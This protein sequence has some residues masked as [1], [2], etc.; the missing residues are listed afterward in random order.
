ML[1]SHSTDENKHSLIRHCVEVAN[2]TKEILD[3]TS[4][5][6][7]EAGFYAGLLHDLGKI[8]PFYQEL[9]SDPTKNK[10]AKIKELESKYLREHSR[11]SA[12][13]AILLLEDKT[14]LDYGTIDIISSVVYAHHSRLLRTL[15][16]TESSDRLAVTQ[17][18]ISEILPEFEN[19]ARP[20]GEFS[21]LNW[22]RCQRYFP[23]PIKFG[24]NLEHASD[25]SMTDFLRIGVLFSALLQADRGSFSEWAKPKFD[26]SI[27]TGPLVKVNSPLSALR[28]SFGREAE[29]NHDFANSVNV[30]NAPTGIGKTKVFLDL[31]SEYVKKFSI[32]RVF[33][34]SP[35]LALTDD[36]E[37]KLK[38]TISEK[39]WGE[40][41]SYTHLFS[42][43]LEKKMQYESGIYEG[44][45]WLF[46]DESFNQKFIITTT[47]RLLMTLY[48]NSY[49]DKIKLASFKNSLLIID[50]IQTIPKF[51]LSNLIE[52][53]QK[54]G[55]LMNCK[56]LLVSATIPYELSKLPR[57]K[58][59]DGILSLYL[60]KTKK[61]ISFSRLEI[62]DM[63]NDKILVMVNTK[64][65]AS[66]IFQRLS[67]GFSDEKL[68]YLSTGV[69]K[70]DRLD[71]L[72]KLSNVNDC[73]CVSTQVI[74]AGVDISFSQIFRE[75]APLDSIVQV[76]GRLNRE[77]SLQNSRLTIFQE[78]NNWVPYSELEYNE[79]LEV[80]K[81]ISTSVDLY[82]ALPEYYHQVSERNQRNR[83]LADALVYSVKKMDFAQVWEFIYSNVLADDYQETVFIPDNEKQWHDLK[84]SIMSA[85]RIDKEISR[86]YSYYTA[87]LSSS[88]TKLGIIDNFDEQLL[89][90][91]ILLPKLEH[92]QEMYHPKIGL[93]VWLTQ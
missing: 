52:Y 93:D 85:G 26:I 15:P 91:N 11:F 22:E 8:N 45:H 82:D 57:T 80:L 83:D 33:Y 53:F 56:I 50:E 89:E 30:L 25:R 1:L 88:P 39:S 79:S 49:S 23:R 40:V 35:L 17:K 24:V 87:A 4:L 77:G 48:S 12:W 60:D 42:G 47:Q 59:S 20:H 72:S 5:N 46:K 84:N 19:E 13:A 43:T 55:E 71:I 6:I 16:E 38:N 34:F 81:H 10:E 28:T 78:D 27:G 7:S 9:F 18:A 44:Y 37:T 58:I 63:S 64:R 36:F 70:K 92:L 21:K 51:V 69:K 32:E 86:K 66:R 68:Y 62:S 75:V 65:K 74:E 3:D 31:I 90:L 67:P 41:L 2:K 61:D 76:M 29:S 14:E 73:L 54:L